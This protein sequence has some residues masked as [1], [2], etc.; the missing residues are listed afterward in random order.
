MALLVETIQAK[1]YKKFSVL[2]RAKKHAPRRYGKARSS[3]RERF[4]KNDSMPNSV[5]GKPA[6]LVHH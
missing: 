2:L 5:E 3:D 1:T 4:E 6:K